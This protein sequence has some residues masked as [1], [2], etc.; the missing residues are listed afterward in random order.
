MQL[1]TNFFQA[2]VADKR[3]ARGKSRLQMLCGRLPECVGSKKRDPVQERATG[4][5]GALEP[6]RRNPV[7]ALPTGARY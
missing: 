2:L 1:W 5:N 3:A 6:T 7:P 4:S